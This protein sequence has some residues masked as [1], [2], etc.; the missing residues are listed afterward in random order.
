MNQVEMAQALGCSQA[1]VNRIRS[2]ER[3][4]S[5][6]LMHKIQRTLAW[7]LEAQIDEVRCGTYA[8]TFTEKMDLRI[9][10]GARVD[11]QAV[12][13]VQR[14]GVGGDGMPT[15]EGER[16]DIGEET[17]PGAGPSDQ[18]DSRAES[19]RA[20]VLDSGASGTIE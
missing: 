18:R 13:G 14:A 5:I 16:G 1:T 3:R 9:P 20:G 19:A 4:P 12:R 6:D 7:P 2:G 11:S 15:L 10:R 8:V 17:G